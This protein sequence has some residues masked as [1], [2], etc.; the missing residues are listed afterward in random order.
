V[1]PREQGWTG[2]LDVGSPVMLGEL[3][4]MGERDDAAYPLRLV[5][6]RERFFYNSSCQV[7]ATNRGRFHN[8]AFLHPDDIAALGLHPG[9]RVRLRSARGEIEAVVEEDSGLRRGLVSMSFAHGRT[10]ASYAER[11]SNVNELTSNDAVF[12]R[13]TGQP[14]MSNVPVRVEAWNSGQA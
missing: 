14:L 7:A 4:A 5:C 9:E 6:R 12:D 1:L 2:R 10:G 13:F 3:A 8:P 11:G